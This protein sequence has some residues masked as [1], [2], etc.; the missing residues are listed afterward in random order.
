MAAAASA[1]EAAVV[2]ADGAEVVAAAAGKRGSPS[3]RRL[4][5]DAVI[6]A[7]DVDPA[8]ICTRQAATRSRAEGGGPEKLGGRAGDAPG[9]ISVGTFGRA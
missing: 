8:S 3:A 6:P 2:V 4:G 1:A 9:V 7:A 5:R